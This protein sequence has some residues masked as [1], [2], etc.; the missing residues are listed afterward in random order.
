M[1]LLERRFHL[2]NGIAGGPRAGRYPAGIDT[3]RNA[4]EA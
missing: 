4:I 1:T 3:L 2:V